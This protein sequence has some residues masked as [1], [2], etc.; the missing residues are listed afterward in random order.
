MPYATFY[1]SCMPKLKV[2]QLSFEDFLAG[3]GLPTKEQFNIAPEKR[4]L[5]IELP[6][7]KI[8]K[9]FKVKDPMWILP[10]RPSWPASEVASHYSTFYI[11][12]KTGGM[13]EI[14]APDEELSM[15]LTNLKYY[16]EVQCLG[17]AHEAAHAYIKERSTVTCVKVHQKNESN[18]FLKLD[19]HDFF[20]SH[21]L[22]YTMKMLSNVFPWCVLMKKKAYRDELRASL[23]YAFLN[24]KLPQGTPLSPTLTNILMNPIDYKIQKFCWGLNKKLAYTRYADD[25]YISSPYKFNMNEIQTEIINILKE[26]NAPFTLNTEKTHFGSRAGRNWILGL[27]L[28]KDNNVTIGHK[29]NQRLRAS[30]NNLMNDFVSG[31]TWSPEDKYAI[32]G[33]LSYAKMVEP[34]YIKHVISTYEKK[35]GVTM[36][37]ILRTV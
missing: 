11:P 22:D 34:D 9:G 36:K 26:F 33:M 13:R 27:M 29:Q 8:K 3:L 25:V 28:N 32:Q 17:L 18:W 15:Y 19:F 31:V 2:V 1:K 16:F 37:Q 7:K 6:Y 20:G 35:Y 30:I 24:N 14:N 4:K 10:Q 21:N 23:E 12:K 5:T